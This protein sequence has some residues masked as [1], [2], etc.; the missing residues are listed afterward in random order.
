MNAK[1][2]KKE[3]IVLPR[4]FSEGKV[5]HYYSKVSWVYDFWS[6]LTESKAAKKV[7]E[8]AE[9]QDGEQILEVAVGTGW[10]FAEIVKRNKSGWNVG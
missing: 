5:K 4:N 7:L 8:L 2:T 9:I 3:R 1:T 6:W 10:V